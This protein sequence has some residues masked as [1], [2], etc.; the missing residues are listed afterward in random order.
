MQEFDYELVYKPGTTNRIA[1]PLSRMPDAQL[2]AAIVFDI[3]AG[4]K[5]KFVKGYKEDEHFKDLYAHMRRAEEERNK[6]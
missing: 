3:D 4:L 1:D 5:D 2:N 6:E